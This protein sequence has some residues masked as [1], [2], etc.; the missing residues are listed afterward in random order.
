MTASDG[1]KRIDSTTMAEPTATLTIIKP[2]E[3]DDEILVADLFKIDDMFA[4][5]KL[6]RERAREKLIKEG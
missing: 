1:P 6:E 5:V 3:E 4:K 2:N